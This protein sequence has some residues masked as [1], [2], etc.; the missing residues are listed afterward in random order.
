MSLD[1]AIDRIVGVGRARPGGAEAFGDQRVAVRALPGEI[2]DDRLGAP[3]GKVLVV[4]FRACGV[5]EAVD[6]ELVALEAVLDARV[7]KRG[8]ELVE[9]GLGGG[10]QVRN[11]RLYRRVRG[12]SSAPRSLSASVP[13]A[14]VDSVR[15]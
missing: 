13:D 1:A 3:L 4:D 5:G 14:A 8:G 2:V 11:N 6:G 9:I 10:G 7:A 12:D 15:A